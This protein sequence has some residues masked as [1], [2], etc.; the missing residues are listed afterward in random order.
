M[1]NPDDA[2]PREISPNFRGN[3]DISL[4]IGL[5]LACSLALQ[6]TTPQAASH[7]GYQVDQETSEG[8]ED[9][10]ARR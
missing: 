1:K 7:S 8:P 9:R 4:E 5:R 10:R 2:I 6:L 3:I